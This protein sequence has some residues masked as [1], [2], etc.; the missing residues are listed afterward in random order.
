MAAPLL[1]SLLSRYQGSVVGGV[2]GDCIGAIFEV[3]W[4]PGIKIEN[5]L[6]MT[7]KIEDGK[8]PYQTKSNVDRTFTPCQ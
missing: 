7:K 1:P 6:V 3:L 8:Y 2:V 4:T 5:V